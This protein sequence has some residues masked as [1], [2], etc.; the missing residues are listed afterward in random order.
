MPAP[1]ES[2][3]VALGERLRNQREY[4]GY[5]QDD[6]ADA[7]GLPRSAISLIENGQRKVDALELKRFSKLYGKPAGYFTGE[8]SSTQ[9]VPENVLA[10]ARLASKLTPNDLTE[11]QRFAEYLQVRKGNKRDKDNG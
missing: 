7:V 11:L 4:L 9:Q 3:R 6:V 8:L 2:E 10:L 1:D 5:S